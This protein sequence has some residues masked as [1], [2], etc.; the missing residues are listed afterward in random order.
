MAKIVIVIITFVFSV[1]FFILLGL[2]VCAICVKGSNS[3][4]QRKKD[5]REGIIRFNSIVHIGGLDVPRGCMCEVYLNPQHLSITCTGSEFILKLEKIKN[6]ECE[7]DVRWEPYLKTTKDEKLVTK[8][9]K[10]VSNY[11]IISYEGTYGDFSNIILRDKY[12]NGYECNRLVRK[13]KPY[14]NIQTRKVEL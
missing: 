9:S 8:T 3:S 11:A 1:L 7:R 10:E 6:I 13:I 2:L 12:V 5:K 14:L 4:K